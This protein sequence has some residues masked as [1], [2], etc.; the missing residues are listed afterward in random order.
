MRQITAADRE[1]A[2]KALGYL[3]YS[4]WCRLPQSMKGVYG[5]DDLRQEGWIVMLRAEENFDETK[6]AKFATYFTRL[7]SN[8][9]ADMFLRDTASRR[10]GN[11]KMV[12]SEEIDVPVADKT[13]AVNLRVDLEKAKQS[14]SETG[15]KLIEFILG[16]GTAYASSN[17][18]SME[19]ATG[20]TYYEVEKGVKEIRARLN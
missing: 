4:F 14:V 9:Y 16:E 11:A 3:S 10:G 18:G 1:G 5:L 8:H 7:L 15:R 19:K 12:P 6:G 2:E 17:N 13:A 20:L